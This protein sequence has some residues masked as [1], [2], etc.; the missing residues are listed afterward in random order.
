VLD[1]IWQNTVCKECF[2]ISK[3]G[4]CDTCNAVKN[5][6]EFGIAM[7]HAQFFP[8]C[9]ICFEPVF[10]SHIECGHYF[11]KTCI[12]EYYKKAETNRLQCPN[13]RVDFTNF[14]K[15]KFYIE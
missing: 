1:I 6:W 2:Q 13:C 4:L 8:V 10:S 9:T 7:G 3:N 11:H 5:S 15:L 12:Q 14:D